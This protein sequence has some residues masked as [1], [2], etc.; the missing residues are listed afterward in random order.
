MADRSVMLVLHDVAP[1]TWVDY[2]S[3]VEAVDALGSVPMT[4]LVVPDFH[5]RN[6]LDE[7][8]QFC[9]MLEQRL[10][11][12]DELVLHGFH[13]LDEA[14]MPRG[15]YEWFMRRVLTHEGEFYALSEADAARRLEQGMAMFRQFGWP[16]HGFVA[17][18]WLLGAGAR[19]ALAATELVYT[20]DVRQLRLLPDFTGIEAPSLVWSARSAW[21]RGLSR[22]VSERLLA[23][24]RQ[25]AVLR[26][27]IHPVDMRHEY[28]RRYWLDT[29]GRLLAD[30]RTPMTKIDWLRSHALRLGAVA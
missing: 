15:P 2:R 18:G 22:Q 11:R 20:S 12:G 26:L 30:G 4:W 3:F 14:P 17:P 23:R 19:R 5:R 9:R 21:R 27:G 13:H 8:P 7:H 28:S 16:L 25:A 1:E 24:H 29:L 6:R 10:A